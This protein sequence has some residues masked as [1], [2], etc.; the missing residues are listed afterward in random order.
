MGQYTVTTPT[1]GK[2][3]THFNPGDT[4]K[5]RLLTFEPPVHFVGARS[6]DI[7]LLHEWERYTC[8]GYRINSVLRGYKGGWLTKV[9]RAE[10][11]NLLIR[12]RFLLTELVAREAQN[13]ET[14]VLVLL[15][16]GLQAVILGC[17]AT[18]GVG[19]GIGEAYKER[20]A[21]LRGHVNDKNDPAFQLR[22]EE[23][24]T[25]GE[26]GLVSQSMSAMIHLVKKR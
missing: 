9:F 12:P 15:V 24:V 17:E 19:Q 21:P 11:S 20:C 25:I 26:F 6:V 5:P 16:E 13:V 23:L 18:G 2:I 4:E 8:R 10:G 22:K 3:Q 14:L 7:R 1:K